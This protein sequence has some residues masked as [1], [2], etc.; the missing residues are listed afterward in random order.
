MHGEQKHVLFVGETKEPRAHQRPG[1][2]IE[3]RMCFLGGLFPNPRIANV[4]R[5]ETQII[6][7]NPNAKYGCDDLHEDAIVEGESRSERL[8]PRY[9]L[10]DA[11]SKGRDVELPPESNRHRH[12]VRRARGLELVQEPEPL[13]CK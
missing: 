7:D 4:W 10:V 3:G 5:E 11:R 1:G 9:H 8:V 2:K 6:N 12:V 13:L